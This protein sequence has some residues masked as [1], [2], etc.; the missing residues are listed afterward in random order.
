MPRGADRVSQLAVQDVDEEALRRLVV[1]D[2]ASDIDPVQAPALGEA[3]ERVTVVDP[4]CGSGAYLIGMM[5]ELLE[6]RYALFRVTKESRR[7]HDLKLHI[8][9]RNLYGVDIDEF[10][11]DIARLRLWLSLAIDYDGDKPQPLPNLNFKIIRG[12]SL[13][14]PD[15][16]AGTVART[17]R[18][19]PNEAWAQTGTTAAAQRQEAQLLRSRTNRRQGPLA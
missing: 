15:P 16:G 14:A 18:T 13:L 4:A 1:E 5:Q 17:R 3:L 12:D 8:I 7:V 19:R 9:E 6:V 10:A 11:V 2:D